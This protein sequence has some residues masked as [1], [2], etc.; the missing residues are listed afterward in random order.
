M[1]AVTADLADKLSKVCGMFGSAHDG[2]RATAAALAD[3]L[4]RDAGLTWPDIIRPAPPPRWLD[5]RD[6]RDIARQCARYPAILTP[7]ECGFL[8]EI[9]GRRAPPSLKQLRVLAEITE[10]AR[11]FAEIMEAAA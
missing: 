9:A 7:W 6:P 2:E 4:V 3:R 11:T 1:T 10:R 8:A 5:L